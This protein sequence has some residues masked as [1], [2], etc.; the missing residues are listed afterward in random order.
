MPV[1]VTVPVPE[2]RPADFAASNSLAAVLTVRAALA[3]LPAVKSL[4]SM[5]IGIVAIRQGV[6]KA[7]SSDSDD[8]EV[9]DDVDDV[10]SV[11][12]DVRAAKLWGDARLCS[13]C[14]IPEISCGADDMSVSASVPTGV[15]A[16]WAVA[17]ACAASPA[18]V[19]V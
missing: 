12:V 3:V 11:A 16:A 8:V 18:G 10:A 15:P 2:P 17:A 5:L 6:L 4:E 19:V 14:G 1:K 9:V 13:V 7:L